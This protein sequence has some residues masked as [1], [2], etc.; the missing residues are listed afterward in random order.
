LLPDIAYPVV[1]TF[2]DGALYLRF[3]R[4][5]LNPEGVVEHLRVYA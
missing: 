1:P 4:Y 5:L 2:T 3:F